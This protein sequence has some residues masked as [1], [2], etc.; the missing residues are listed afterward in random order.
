MTVNTVILENCLLCVNFWEIHLYKRHVRPITAER[1]G[2]LWLVARGIY[3]GEFI[4]VNAQKE[5]I[6]Y[7]GVCFYLLSPM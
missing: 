3:G 1:F 4:K 7:G 6:F 2:D 5:P